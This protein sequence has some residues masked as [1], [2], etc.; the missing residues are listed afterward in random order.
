MCI[1]GIGNGKGGD[2]GSKVIGVIATEGKVGNVSV[3]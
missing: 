2:A 3:E 1:G